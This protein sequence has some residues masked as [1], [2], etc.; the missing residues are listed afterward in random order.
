MGEDPRRYTAADLRAFVVAQA[1]RYKSGRTGMITTTVRSF[2]KCQVAMGRCLT[3]LIGAIPA[4]R[5]AR[6][7]ELPRYLPPESV[8]RIIAVAG[9][10]AT[11]GERDRAMIL[12]LA[13]LG[14]RAGDVVGLRLGDIDWKQARLRVVGK[15]RRETW[16]PL[17]QDAGDAIL[18]YYRRVRPKAED[19]HVFLTT[20]APISPLRSSQLSDQVAAAIRRAGVDAPFTGARVLRHS[21][22]T[23]MLRDGATL[24]AIGAVLRHRSVETTALYAKVDMDLLRLVAQPWPVAVSRC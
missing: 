9:D 24:D 14:L 12:L 20:H 21:L 17:P 5:A 8:E 4:I 2:L 10:T 7:A 1:K 18:E 22:A 19:D 16:L 6:L 3:D 23:R 15:G 13:R 11:A